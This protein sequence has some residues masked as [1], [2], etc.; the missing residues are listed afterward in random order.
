MF[1][2]CRDNSKGQVRLAGCPLQ[3]PGK[4][5]SIHELGFDLRGEGVV[6]VGFYWGKGSGE[7]E[8]FHISETDLKLTI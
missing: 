1:C 6:I 5:S 8:S 2:L 7:I 3:R 4:H